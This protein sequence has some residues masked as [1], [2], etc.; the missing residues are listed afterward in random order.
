MVPDGSG[1][2][3][4]TKGG[5]IP[6][7]GRIAAVCDVF[8]ALTSEQPYK[9][10]WSVEEGIAFIKDN[11]GSHMDPELVRLFVEILSE[12]LVIREEYAEDAEGTDMDSH[13]LPDRQALGAE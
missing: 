3:Y 13:L 12:I 1:Y 9:K 6:I 10:A 8:D 4:G 5:E 2:P 11:A 7:E